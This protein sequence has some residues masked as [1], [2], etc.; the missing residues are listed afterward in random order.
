VSR[1]LVQVVHSVR[2]RPVAWVLLASAPA[3][4]FFISPVAAAMWLIALIAS[5]FVTRGHASS[6]RRASQAGHRHLPRI[7]DSCT[8]I[9][10]L[11]QAVISALN[12]DEPQSG[13]QEPPYRSCTTARWDA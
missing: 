4:P 2:Q 3:S 9:E 6:A 11:V 12:G 10:T 7:S 13:D 5:T 1:S 8:E